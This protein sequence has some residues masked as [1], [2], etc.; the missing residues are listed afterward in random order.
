MKTSNLTVD[1]EFA[2]ICGGEVWIFQHML[3]IADDSYLVG[4]EG[5]QVAQDYR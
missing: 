5:R 3:P 2:S 1:L 4:V